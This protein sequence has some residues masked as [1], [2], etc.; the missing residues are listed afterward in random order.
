MEIKIKGAKLTVE[1]D[2][3]LKEAVKANTEE[4]SLQDFLIHLNETGKEMHARQAGNRASDEQ[5]VTH[6]KKGK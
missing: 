6:Y 3:V 4:M 5:N 2:D 1:S